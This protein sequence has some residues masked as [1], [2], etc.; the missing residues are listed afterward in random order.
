LCQPPTKAFAAGERLYNELSFLLSSR[1]F[2]AAVAPGEFLDAPGGI[3]ELLF[4]SEKGMTSGTNTD[5]NIATRGAG[6]IHRAARANHVGLVIL[7]MNASFH[8]SNGARNVAAWAVSC[9]R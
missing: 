1:R 4:A 6:M 8:L 2:G 9:K 5:L 7:W 3:D